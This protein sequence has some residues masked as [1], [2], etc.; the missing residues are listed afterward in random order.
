MKIYNEVVLQYNEATDS[1]I[2]VSEDSF[3][4]EGP[5]AQ[6]GKGGGGGGG[7]S[8]EVKFAAYIEDYH[9]E[10]MDGAGTD[11]GDNIV[12]DSSAAGSVDQNDNI[13]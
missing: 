8:G 1:F 9:K 6:C 3:E 4:Y 11:N 12:M 5:V 7:S 13:T 10:L 2:E